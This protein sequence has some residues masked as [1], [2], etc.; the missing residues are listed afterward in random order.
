MI[1]P[2]YAPDW[3]EVRFR[4]PTLPSSAWSRKKESKIHKSGEVIHTNGRIVDTSP[5]NL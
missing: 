3:K 4:G 5:N 2:T 1:V